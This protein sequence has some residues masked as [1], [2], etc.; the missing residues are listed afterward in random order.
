MDEHG[1][2]EFKA[3]GSKLDKKAKNLKHMIYAMFY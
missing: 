1:F 2:S 3:I